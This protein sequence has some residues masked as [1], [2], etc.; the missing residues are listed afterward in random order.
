MSRTLYVH[1]RLPR[2]TDVPAIGFCMHT[3]QLLLIRTP[4]VQSQSSRPTRRPAWR[5]KTSA[6]GSFLPR[7]LGTRTVAVPLARAVLTNK[8]PLAFSGD[9]AES[10][11]KRAPSAEIV[12]AMPL[13]TFSTAFALTFLTAVSAAQPG[14][15]ARDSVGFVF[16]RSADAC[17]DSSTGVARLIHLV[18]GLVRS[19]VHR[20]L[21]VTTPRRSELWHGP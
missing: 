1:T 12:F 2:A 3:T 5:N 13:P 8:R 6:K 4:N 15:W 11:S 18:R 21:M 14:R 19:F 7:K 10:R 9:A 20:G 17:H 16:C